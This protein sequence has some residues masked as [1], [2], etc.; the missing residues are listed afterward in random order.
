MDFVNHTGLKAA[1]CLGF[2]LEGREVMV[3]VV[4]AT[5]ALGPQGGDLELAAEQAPLVKADEFTGEPG[6]SATLYETDFSHRKPLCD[7]LVVGSAHSPGARP[8]KKVTVGLRV[9]PIHKRFEVVGNRTWS[10]RLIGAGPGDAAPF[11]TM[12]IT[13]DRAYGG[14]DVGGK[15]QVRTFAANPIGIGYYPLSKGKAL[16]G[17][18]LANTQEIGKDAAD[19]NG[20]FRPMSF[21]PIGRNFAERVP[22][23]GTY[24]EA[25]FEERLPLLP[26]DFDD[27]YF[28]CAPADQQ[29]PHPRGGEVV[30]LE[31]LTPAG[32]TRFRLPSREFPVLVVRKD[33]P[34]AQIDPVLDTILIEPDLGR[35]LLTWRGS[36]GLRRDVFE[37]ART[38]VGG[39]LASH[40]T[41]LRREDK[42]HYANLD[43]MARARRDGGR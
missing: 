1:W 7:V 39:T 14:A 8:A 17:K 10:G 38:E 6:L 13:Y 35:A 31:N 30:E 42:T 24:D 25:Y 3:V 36:I 41:E 23:A 19:R 2:D 16:D 21:G 18:P 27:R 4:K 22:Y 15:D 12:P 28:Q 34:A 32:L 33:G 26:A 29:M 43:E 11:V 40:E 5:Y 9:G 20:K 37:V